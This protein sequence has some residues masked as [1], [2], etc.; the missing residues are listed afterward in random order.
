MDKDRKWFRD[1][2]GVNDKKPSVLS[3]QGGKH[4]TLTRNEEGREWFALILTCGKDR[5]SGRKL[6]IKN[7]V[8]MKKPSG[9]SSAGRVGNVPKIKYGKQFEGKGSDKG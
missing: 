5:V 6:Q 4:V 7:R 3:Q 1:S 8:H 2:Q 9:P